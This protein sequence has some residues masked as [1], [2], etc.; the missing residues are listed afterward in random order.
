[1]GN[2]HKTIG[3]GNSPYPSIAVA[4]PTYQR[5][6]VL[7]QTVNEILK[8]SIV[9]NEFVIIDQS[10]EHL[11]TTIDFLQKQVR[12]G[13]L[14][15]IK[16]SPP[17]LS[18]ARNRAL[19]ETCSEIILFIDDDILTHVDF[20]HAHL[21]NYLDPTID[22][23]CGQVR[24]IDGSV[25]HKLPK[26]IN[27]N[28]PFDVSYKLPRNFSK[29]VDAPGVICGCN[30]SIRRKSMRVIVGFNEYITMGGEDLDTGFRLAE[31]GC[32]IVFDPN[33]WILHLQPPN[34]GVR[35]YVKRTWDQQWRYVV[36]RPYLI[37]R[38]IKNNHLRYLMRLIKDFLRHTILLK[39]N[40]F[41]PIRQFFLLAICIKGIYE[42]YYWSKLQKPLVTIEW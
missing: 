40:I 10:E 4:I 21:A 42:A 23:V 39:R 9:P 24:P 41:H 20:I 28:N 35:P 13:K 22:A 18:C 30:F 33:S 25:V 2:S 12:E 14:R 5:E 6:E 29:R 8:Q 31:Q 3:E 11:P 19:K 26:N 37:F 16:H 36:G 7:C 1:M 34:G 38:F 17:S 15:W 32:R 27:W